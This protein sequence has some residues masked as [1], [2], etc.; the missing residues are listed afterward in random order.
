M[1]I[2]SF[3]TYKSG[4]TIPFLIVEVTSPPAKYAPRNSKIAAIKIACLKVMALLPTDVPIALATSLAPMPNA[5]KN[6]AKAAIKSIIVGSKN[7]FSIIL[8]SVY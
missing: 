7:K 8:Y 2:S 6:P 5:I 4:D 1:K 3:P